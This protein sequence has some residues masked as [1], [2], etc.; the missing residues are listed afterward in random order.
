VEGAQLFAGLRGFA[1]LQRSL[2]VRPALAFDESL[3]NATAVELEWSA[4]AAPSAALRAFGGRRL[5]VALRQTL[6]RRPGDGDALG[7]RLFLRREQL[8]QEIVATA[9]DPGCDR[10][11]FRTP[12]GYREAGLLLF[13][14]WRAQAGVRFA[15]TAQLEWRRYDGQ[16]PLGHLDPSGFVAD[17]W[18]GRT[19]VDLRFAPSASIEVAL[20]SDLDLVLRYD[21]VVNRSNVD[22]TAPGHGTDFDNKNFV[23]ET[24]GAGLSAHW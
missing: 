6:R 4:K 2:T 24:M 20:R 13:G 22:R 3:H 15:A 14:T 12:L 18:P 5:E 16:T 8:G 19:R 17:L 21:L 10:G 1:A 23:K 9:D 11:C 7:A